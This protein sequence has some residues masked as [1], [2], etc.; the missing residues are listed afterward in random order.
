M[1]LKL[2]RILC[3]LVGHKRVRKLSCDICERCRVV[4][5][6]NNEDAS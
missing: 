5:P 4:L 1:E 6:S 2:R 3:R